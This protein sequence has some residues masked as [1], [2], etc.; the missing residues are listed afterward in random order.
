MSTARFRVF[1]E[2][3]HVHEATVVIDRNAGVF[4]VRPLRRRRTY[5]LP[6]AF[7]AR[8]VMERIIKAEAAEKRAARRK[9]R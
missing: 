7:V 4:S 3:D 9:K 5:E 1:G 8:V 2:F 6:L